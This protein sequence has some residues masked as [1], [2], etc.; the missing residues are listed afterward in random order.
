MTSSRLPINAQVALM[1][2]Y[3]GK[4]TVTGS[5]ADRMVVSGL[6]LSIYKSF[7]V[8]FASK[9]ASASLST[10][11]V[12]I[13]G[14][15][16][17]ANYYRSYIQGYS[18]GP[19]SAANNGRSNTNYLDD[20]A[21]GEIVTGSIDIRKDFDGRPR[22]AVRTDAYSAASCGIGLHS[23]VRNNTANVTSVGLSS[24]ASLGLSVG[25]TMTV[26][27]LSPA[28]V[29][30]G[31]S[32]GP[33]LANHFYANETQASGTNGGASAAGLNT[34]VLNTAAINNIAGASLASNQVTLP[35]GT[36]WIQSRAAAFGPD[37]CKLVLYNVTDSAIAIGGPVNYANGSV[38]AE[39]IAEGYLTIAASKVFELR[40]YIQTGNGNA[41]AL[42]ISNAAVIGVTAAEIYAEFRAWK[43]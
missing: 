28:G 9:N 36:Y 24:F 15:T 13:N 2:I 21:A 32:S 22:C 27:G 17:V 20:M 35:A 40:H 7:H 41:F 37:R 25:D 38:V 26:W 39:V 34:R 4:A 42:G 31:A 5:P 16:T 14:D 3:L 12:E 33:T 19:A 1:M 10:L 6:D 18:A 43:V 29:A 23:V 30:L 8:E 11:R